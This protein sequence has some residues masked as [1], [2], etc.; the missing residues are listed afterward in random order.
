MLSK[1]IKRF[2]SSKQRIFPNIDYKYYPPEGEEK[3]TAIILLGGSSGGVPSYLY[4]PAIY[5]NYPVM[6]LGYF[7]TKNTSKYQKMIPLEFFDEAIEA[8]KSMDRVKG[9]KI[10]VI[11]DSKGGEVALLLA[12]N[13]SKVDG[14][15]AR[16]PSSV[17][18]QGYGGWGNAS[19]WSLGGS[20]MAYVP[21]PQYD[22]SSVKDGKWLDMYNK[23][24][25]QDI[26]MEEATIKVENIK[27]P[28]LLLTG[29]DDIVWPATRMC[30]D[31]I[32]RLDK[33][34][35][36]Y[37]YE[38]IAYTDAGHALNNSCPRGGTIEGNNYALKHSRIKVTEFLEKLDNM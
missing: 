21:Y 30:N 7:Q 29:V 2:K 15:I 18:F 9:K 33:K 27:G 8:F 17:V 35:F 25:S 10:V 20:P 23:A 34:N 31:I 14:V 37:S 19:G 3:G 13:N 4:D 5:T 36:S 16:V 1:I 28:I 26:N 11:G 6:A 24:L 38:H 32:K 12:A 22:Y